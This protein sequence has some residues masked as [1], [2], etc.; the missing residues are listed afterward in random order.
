MNMTN[1]RPRKPGWYWAELPGAVP[2][3]PV[4]VFEDDDLGLLYTF[5]RLRV[6]DDDATRD[7]LAVSCADARFLWSDA[8]IPKP[9]A[10]AAMTPLQRTVLVAVMACGI[11]VLGT[12]ER[13]ERDAQA[14][15]LAATCPGQ[16]DLVSEPA[17]VRGVQ[18]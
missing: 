8:P 12:L 17:Q 10:K 14:R 13:A 15:F 16:A 5:D 7:G 2:L 9:T 3:Q 6:E 18:L 11:G 4:L 1:R